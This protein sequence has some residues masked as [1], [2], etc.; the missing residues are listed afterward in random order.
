MKISARNVL[1]GKVKKLTHGA[2]N[3]EITLQMPAGDGNRFDHHQEF[4]KEIGTEQ[5]K[6]GLCGH[7][8][9]QRDDRRGLIRR[10]P[11]PEDLP[12]TRQKGLSPGTA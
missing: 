8:G 1:K 2:V 5:G 3:S 4:G 10:S 12:F 11:R 9:L 6:T 7:Q